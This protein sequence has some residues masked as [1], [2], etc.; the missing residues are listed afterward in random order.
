MLMCH[1]T[2]FE[3]ICDLR[4][5]FIGTPPL[6]SKYEGLLRHLKW[7][8]GDFRD[9]KARVPKI[10]TIRRC[11]KSLRIELKEYFAKDLESDSG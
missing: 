9:R 10:E 5:G 3:S 2:K 4:T 6:Y 11:M 7:W 8:T 1:V